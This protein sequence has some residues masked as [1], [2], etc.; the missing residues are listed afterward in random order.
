MA[1]VRLFWKRLS[2]KLRSEYLI[3]ALILVLAAILQ[4]Y[5]I[6][7]PGWDGTHYSSS[8]RDVSLDGWH[9]YCLCE[10]GGMAKNYFKFGYLETKL[11]LMM[12]RGWIKPDF[13]SY[14]YRVDHPPLLP[15]LISLSY[16]L[17]G[18]HEWSTRLVTLL[19][20]LGLLPLV[21]LAR[22]QVRWQG[23]SLARLLLFCFAPRAGLLRRASCSTCA[24]LVLLLANHCLLPKVGGNEKHKMVCGHIS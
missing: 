10:W 1:S 15:F 9:G 20:S 24:G 22:P 13:S 23:S 11:G 14:R 21:F 2:Q 3:L 8:L 16:R 12:H 4:C 7:E 5:R 18:V 17:F 19:T 6:A